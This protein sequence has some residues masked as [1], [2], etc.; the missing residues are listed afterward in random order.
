MESNGEPLKIHISP[1]CKQVLDELGGYITEKRGIINLKGKG[2]IMTYWLIGSD[3]T[4][5]QK[6]QFDIRDLP[7]PL[8]CRPRKSPK[9]TMD[10]RHPSIIGGMFYGMVTTGTL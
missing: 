8:F 9:L 6:R 5:I 10:S 1:Q 3:E 4:A 7:P 2:D